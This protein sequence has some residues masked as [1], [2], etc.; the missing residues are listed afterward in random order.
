MGN[1]VNS[2]INRLY[3]N[4][5]GRESDLAGLEHWVD[6]ITNSNAADVAK[7][8][9][10]S[11]EFINASHSD[12]E[13]IQ[14]TYLT[15]MGREYDE[16]GMSHWQNEL[17]SGLSRDG[18]LDSFSSSTE[19]SVLAESY[20]IEAYSP[21]VI[22]DNSIEGFVARF[23][24]EVL[25]RNPDSAGLNN[26]V[27]QLDDSTLTADDIAG[28][29]FSSQEFINQNTS[30]N[31]FV[32]IA[33]KTLLGR[34]ADEAG[35][36]D[37]ETGLDNGQSRTEMLD[38]FIY[39]SEFKALANEYGIS[40]GERELSNSTPTE[41]HDYSS[42]SDDIVSITGSSREVWEENGVRQEDDET[43]VITY[44]EDGG[45]TERWDWVDGY[46]IEE[47]DQF[48]NFISEVEYDAAGNIIP[49]EY[50]EYEISAS[51]QESRLYRNQYGNEHT[52][53]FS[54]DVLY[55]YDNAGQFL[56]ETR[57]ETVIE[58]PHLS[59]TEVITWYIDQEGAVD[60]LYG[61]DSHL[62]DIVSVTASQTTVGADQQESVET[63]S[64]I[65]QDGGGFTGTWTWDGGSEVEVYDQFG[66]EISYVEYDAAGNI[67][68]DVNEDDDESDISASATEYRLYRDE[69]GNEHTDVIRVD[70]LYFYDAAGQFEG[71][72]YTETV[73]ESNHLSGTVV[74]LLGSDWDFISSEGSLWA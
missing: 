42:H 1:D 35:L 32:N 15:F 29:F 47:F 54:I 20:G 74:T 9:Y 57:T 21:P 65:Y 50:D 12:F 25:G 17:S 70:E 51:G 40:V 10:N 24:T 4:V 43:Y 36:N 6:I 23:Y 72:S 28:G 67:V 73:I 22:S 31:E 3:E 8:F 59:G 34:D 71:L 14:T 49:D 44:L 18:L 11:E 38:G 55:L 52:D 30:N 61:Y 64:I 56:G 66:N 41:E 69:F 48:G 68:L 60:E 46:E 26:W 53:V 33:Y 5:L 13:F 16:S 7:S 39:S 37:W 27:N 62:N 58:S 19:F 45:R 63:Y 2:F